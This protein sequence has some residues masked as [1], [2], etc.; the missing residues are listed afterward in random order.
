V[1]KLCFPFLDPPLPGY[2]LA[3]GTMPVSTAVVADLGVSTLAAF[4]L[5]A[6]QRGSAT[7]LD[8]TKGTQYLVAGRVFG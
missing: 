6:T 1:Q 3:F 7:G 8:R 5:M 4:F 2:G